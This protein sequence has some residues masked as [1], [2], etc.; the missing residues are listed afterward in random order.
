MSVFSDASPT[1]QRG[2]KNLR[3]FDTILSQ[4]FLTHVLNLL[5][6]PSPRLAAGNV[7]PVTAVLR[8][9]VREKIDFQFAH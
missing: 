8:G 7:L 1:H 6:E 4:L 5:I 3:S 2:K 9:N